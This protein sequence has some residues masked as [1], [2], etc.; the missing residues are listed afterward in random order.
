[1]KLLMKEGQSIFTAC[2]LKGCD[3]C[4]GMYLDI[5]IISFFGLLE[6]TLKTTLIS[7]CSACCQCPAHALGTHL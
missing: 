7:H 5:W 2:S 4:D 3:A 1:M 6:S